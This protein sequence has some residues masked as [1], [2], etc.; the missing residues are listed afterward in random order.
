M[1]IDPNK[2]FGEYS[3][4][5]MDEK[6]DQNYKNKTQVVRNR[7]IHNVDLPLNPAYVL[8]VSSRKDHIKPLFVAF[9]N[10]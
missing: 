9:S 7:I 2:Y 1:F 6:D 8:Y 4:I 3:V 10:S 5:I